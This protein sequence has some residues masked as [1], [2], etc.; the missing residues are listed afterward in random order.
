MRLGVGA[1]LVDGAVIT[2]DIDVA[3]GRVQQ[4]G[5]HPAGRGIASPGFVDLQVNGFAG[6]DFLAAGVDDYATAGQGLAATG[7]TAYLPTFITAPVATLEAAAAVAARAAE[8][9]DGPRVLGVHL[10]GPFLSPSFMGAHNPAHR[11]E[12]DLGVADRLLDAGPVRL[13]TLAAERPGGAALVEHLVARGVAVSLGHTDADAG[14]AHDAFDRGA[15]AVTHLHNAMRR[16]GAR[17][18]GV[19]G[20]AL[21]R[22]DVTVQL[23]ADRLHLADETVQLAWS[24]AADRLVLVTDAIAAA[25]RGSGTVVLGDRTVHVSG[26]GARLADGT[27]AGSV[28][29]MDA[30]VRNLVDLGADR[31]GALRA[32]SETPARLVG[33]P[34]TL[35]PGAAAD[36]VVLDDDLAVRRTLVGGGERFAA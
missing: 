20:V 6:V 35:R 5:L 3:D 24:A 16:W 27:L 22:G 9:V 28:L 23:I 11:L 21:V 10:E 33:H 12:P 19:G 26:S 30:A 31:L 7:V 4:V 8:K 1:A 15:A 13:M 34:A 2:G 14:V 32:A 17:D 25:G 18:P 36:V 29:T